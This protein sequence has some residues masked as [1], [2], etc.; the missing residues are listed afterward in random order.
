[1]FESYLSSSQPHVEGINQKVEKLVF[2]AKSKSPSMMLH[3]CIKVSTTNK[4][5]KKKRK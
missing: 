2:I 1:V 3:S 4:E 5:K